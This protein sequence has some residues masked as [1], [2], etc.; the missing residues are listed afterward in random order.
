MASVF[1]SSG[2]DRGLAL[3]YQKSNQSSSPMEHKAS[4][5]VISGAGTANPSGAPEFIPGF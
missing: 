1:A 4:M 2:V 3:K 5:Y